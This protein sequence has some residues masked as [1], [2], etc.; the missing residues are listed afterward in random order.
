MAPKQLQQVGQSPER[1]GQACLQRPSNCNCG[2]LS[3]HPSSPLLFRRLSLCCPQPFCTY[4]MGK[5]SCASQ[6]V[7]QHDQ[8]R[9]A[10][11]AQNAG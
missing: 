7:Q 6:P 5:R 4:V 8:C 10:W 2:D 11:Q 3:P 9:H 1:Q